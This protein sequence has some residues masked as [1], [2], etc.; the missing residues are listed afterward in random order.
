[1]KHT[2]KE[3]KSTKIIIIFLI[4]IIIVAAVV[5]AVK[6]INSK[7]GKEVLGNEEQ[8][9]DEPVEVKKL[10]IVDETSKS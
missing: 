4:L 3:N 8:I 7:E 9:Q 5:L 1:M 10:Q 6:V 2:N